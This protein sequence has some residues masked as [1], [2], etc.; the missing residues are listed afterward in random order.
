M[1]GRGVKRSASLRA[2]RR[3]Q[4]RLR[5][6]KTVRKWRRATR[7]GLKGL[8]VGA[9]AKYVIGKARRI[10]TARKTEVFK[11][12]L[13][14]ST[15]T[16]YDASLTDIARGTGIDQRTEDDIKVGGYRI[17]AEVQNLQP[18][19]L[20]VNI[21]VVHHRDTANALTHEFFRHDGSVRAID[22]SSALSSLELH[23]N[24]LN[25]DKFAILKHRRYLLN[26]FVNNPI[27][28]GPIGEGSG[29]SYM[30]ID[31]Y[32]PIGRNLTFDNNNATAIDAQS[33]I[34]LIWWVDDYL[35]AA[36][37]AV[38]GGAAVIQWKVV[39][40]HHDT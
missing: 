31:W 5:M 8:A 37:T 38:A 35:A 11:D 3:A 39:A 1:A 27:G 7:W 13:T 21:A 19:P 4:K 22:F 36:G 24:P 34:F 20:Y 6:I 12:Y 32:I 26:C 28:S 2:A 15:R 30:N 16:L 10:R 40:Y 9:A 18:G 23:G 17:K 33:N 25:T 14:P 29:K